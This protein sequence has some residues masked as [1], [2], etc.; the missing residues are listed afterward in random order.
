MSKNEKISKGK[1]KA[2]GAIA[3]FKT[4]ISQGNVMDMAVGVIMGA[5]FGKIVTSLVNDIL[6]PIVGLVLGK[7]DFSALDGVSL[8]ALPHFIPFK[9]EFNI[10]AILSVTL[11]FLVSATETIGDVSALA[12]SGLDRNVQEKETSGAIAC[13]G[14]VS[15][16]STV[17]GCIP[18]TSFSQN[19]GLIAMT[20]V[21]NRMV[22]STGAVIMLLAGIFPSIGAILATL[23]DAVLGGCTIMMFGNI[24][25]S[26]LQ[27]LGRCGFS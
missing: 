8:I 25:I 21:V 13:D 20:K 7:V 6:M 5:A 2:K 11:I 10:G 4:F 24:V 9:P 3:E 26:G 17:F 1:A 27:M 12:I 15:A 16:F 19:I 23:P 22:I 14:F 18:I